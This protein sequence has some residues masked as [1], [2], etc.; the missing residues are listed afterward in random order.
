MGLGYH[1]SRAVPSLHLHSNPRSHSCH[2]L[3]GQAADQI[4]V[5]EVMICI[6]L[7]LLVGQSISY[8]TWPPNFKE[9]LRGTSH[10]LPGGGGEQKSVSKTRS[11]IGIETGVRALSN[12]VRIT[13]HGLQF[14]LRNNSSE[15]VPGVLIV[16][17]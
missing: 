15:F 4:P 2:G 13:Y 7:L 9:A 1:P 16:D 10:V 5:P 14:V 3:G 8:V 11:I 6:V 12:W 17:L